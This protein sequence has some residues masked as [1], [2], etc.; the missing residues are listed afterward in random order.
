MYILGSRL[1]NKAF[2]TFESA[3]RDAYYLEYDVLGK[4]FVRARVIS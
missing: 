4:F 1:M 2:V 3:F